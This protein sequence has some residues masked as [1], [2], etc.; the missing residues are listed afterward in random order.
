MLLKNFIFILLLT[1]IF[2][3][4]LYAKRIGGD[5]QMGGERAFWDSL[6]AGKTQEAIKLLDNGVNP[7]TMAP[8]PDY[9]MPA[10]IYATTQGYS[11]VVDKLVEKQVYLDAKGGSSDGPALYYAITQF[12]T[13][14]S[15]LDGTKKPTYNPEKVK[16]ALHLINA[17]A[18][19]EDTYL[20]LASQGGY[21]EIV[22]ALIK[23]GANRGALDIYGLRASAYARDEQT[24][25]L[26]GKDNV[27]DVQD[28]AIKTRQKMDDKFDYSKLWPKDSQVLFIGEY[29]FSKFLR[30][31]AVDLVEKLVKQ[32]VVITHFGTEFI[33]QDDQPQIDKWQKGEPVTITQVCGAPGKWETYQPI[34]EKIKSNKI[35]IIALDINSDEMEKRNWAWIEKIRG[36]IKNNPNA[37]ILV[38]CG[39]MHSDYNGFPVA[40]SAAL[41]EYKISTTVISLVGEDFYINH[42]TDAAIRLGVQNETFIA[43]VKIKNFAKITGADFFINV[44]KK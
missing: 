32:G 21:F 24:L 1:V 16:I 37:R 20:H 12:G 19:I 22:N 9:N 41:Q 25:K 13:G 8:P 6:F 42:M 10:I 18:Q 2:S 29:H 28:E 11:N 36:I 14:Y 30:N 44:P 31:T 3:N 26:L 5:V 38:Y 15:Y 34:N 33:C 7:N 17:G 23:K 39:S 43:P 35:P 27:T 40:V 4:Q